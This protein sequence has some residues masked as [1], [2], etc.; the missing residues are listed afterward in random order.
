M[1]DKSFCEMIK[2]AID[3]EQKAVPFY[4]KLADVFREEQR[5]KLTDPVFFTSINSL[6]TELIDTIAKDENKHK[7]ILEKINLLECRCSTL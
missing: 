2:E 3:D 1:S 6:M 7:E 4:I 5:K